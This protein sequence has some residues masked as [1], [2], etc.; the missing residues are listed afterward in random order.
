[1]NAVLTVPAAVASKPPATITQAELQA[2]ID[3]QNRLEILA[4][5][6]RKRL[7]SG[8]RLEPGR[9]GASAVTHPPLKE[10]AVGNAVQTD[11]FGILTIEP[12]G[13]IRRERKRYPDFAHEMWVS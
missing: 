7:E 3:A 6:I 8:A 2:V 4:A 9:L 5:G 12:G 13:R 11:G 10:L 1:M